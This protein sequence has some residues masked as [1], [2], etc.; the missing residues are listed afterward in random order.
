MIA[1][2]YPSRNGTSTP[3]RLRT[4]T[5]AAAIPSAASAILDEEM[6][7]LCQYYAY[8]EII[9]ERERDIFRPTDNGTSLWTRLP[10]GRREV[11]ELPDDAHRQA[12][13]H[14]SGFPPAFRQAARH[15]ARRSNGRRVSMSKRAPSRVF[16][17]R[18]RTGPSTRCRGP[19]TRSRRS[20]SATSGSTSTPTSSKSSRPSRCSTPIRRSACR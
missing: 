12:S 9:D 2:R 18:V 8:V 5:T 20:R 6:M 7:K 10:A 14:L 4:A 17:S 1:D 13:G 19:M 15:G 11:A 16:C 3:P